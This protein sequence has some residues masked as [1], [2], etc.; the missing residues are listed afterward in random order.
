MAKMTGRAKKTETFTT[1]L[2]PKEKYCLELLARLSGQSIAK[3]LE[4]G[5]RIQAKGTSVEIAGRPEVSATLDNMMSVL[6]SPQEWK[7]IISLAAVSPSLLSHVEEC[8]LALILQSKTLCS[9]PTYG[10]AG[11]ILSIDVKPRLIEIA[12]PLIE[13]RAE[14]MAQGR[15]APA[16]TLSEIEAYREQA[17]ETSEDDGLH[18]DFSVLHRL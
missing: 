5:I 13:E 11:G 4:H 9:T 16:P 1:R 14:E 15:P 8:K 6:W 18:M 3:T 7:R 10:D 12:W 2:E 17:I